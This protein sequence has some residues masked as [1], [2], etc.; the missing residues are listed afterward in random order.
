M[1]KKESEIVH[2]TIIRPVVEDVSV[3][4]PY[5]TTIRNARRTVWETTGFVPPIT[6]GHESFS[7]TSE[8]NE[9]ILNEETVRKK[10]EEILD[11]KWDRETAE[12]EAAYRQKMVDLYKLRTDYP[13]VYRELLES[14]RRRRY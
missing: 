13:D 6:G 2:N 3:Q 8:T 14:R 12:G 1:H 4:A 5:E 10:I 7:P 9:V 11:A